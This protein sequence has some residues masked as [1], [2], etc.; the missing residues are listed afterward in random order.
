MGQSRGVDTERELA[1]LEDHSRHF[2]DANL[3]I[4]FSVEWDQQ[5]SASKFYFNRGSPAYITSER[6][7]EEAR[8]VVE[9]CRRQTLQVATHVAMEFDSGL[10]SQLFDDIHR[11]IDL[12]FDDLKSPVKEY[13]EYNRPAF[14]TLSGDPP[15]QETDRIKSE[16]RDDYKTPLR[17]LA[18]L[19]HDSDILGIWTEAPTDHEDIYDGLYESLD[20]IMTNKDDRDLLLD[21]HDFLVV[22]GRDGLLVATLDRSDFIDDREALES[23]LDPIEIVD[24]LGLY[25]ETAAGQE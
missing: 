10:E 15:E 2:I 16:I 24:L 1:R 3:L 14:R 8:G 13:V 9:Q 22:T 11:F 4:G 21:A 18:K 6:V 25:R 12:H 7:Y 17:F 20:D 23:V 5:N 19:C